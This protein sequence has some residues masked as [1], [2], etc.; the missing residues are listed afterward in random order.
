MIITSNISQKILR[1]KK[2]GYQKSSIVVDSKIL[3]CE[4]NI[5]N[6]NKILFIINK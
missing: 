4:E 2:F 1:N 6:K 5:Y 3:T